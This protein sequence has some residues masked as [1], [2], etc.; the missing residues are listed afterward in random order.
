[1]SGWV[2]TLGAI[3]LGAMLM[4][5]IVRADLILAAPPRESLERGAQVYAGL[6]ELLSRRL[7]IKVAYERPADWAEYINNMRQ[8]KYD[9]VFDGPHFASWR[10]KHLGHVPVVRFPSKLS[11]LVVGHDEIKKGHGLRSIVNGGLCALPSPN[12]G[13]VVVMSQFDN[14]DVQPDVY[15]VTSWR[16]AYNAYLAGHCGAAIMQVGFFNQLPPNERKELR[17]LYVSPAFPNQ[18]VTVSNRVSYQQRESISA[19]LL[20][21]EGSSV[22]HELFSQFN[23]V[24]DH[25]ELARNDEYIGLERFLEG[26]MWGW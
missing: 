14:P 10:I 15:E 3:F 5:E 2:S 8:G 9:V 25:F 18:T 21:E 4:S 6:A 17:V 7:G 1:M 20:D 11:F 23:I 16:E 24:A 22:E 13:T 12:F 19:A 26:T